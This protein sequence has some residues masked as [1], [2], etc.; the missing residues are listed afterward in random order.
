[1][2]P[3]V[4][5]SLTLLLKF[6]L[7]G[8]LFYFLSQKGLLSL[9]ATR[10]AFQRWDLLLLAFVCFLTATLISIFRWQALLKAQ[11]I[12][13]PFAM[14]LKLSFVGYFFNVALPGAVSG[15]V[16]K[17]VYVAKEAPGKRAFAFSSIII[18]RLIG[19]S[20]LVMVASIAWGIS[21]M[22]PAI[23]GNASLWRA[24]ELTVGSAGLAVFIF[25]GYLFLVPDRHDWIAKMLR[26]LEGKS[27][28]FGSLTRIYEGLRNYSKHRG[29]VVGTLLIS[30]CIHVLVT[31]GVICCANAI[32]ETHIDYLSFYLVVPLGMII[33]AIPVLPAGIGTGHAAFLTLFKLLGSDRGVDVFN[34]YILSILI[35]AVLGGFVYLFSKS[36]YKVAQS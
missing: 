10:A 28:K 17:A 14:T 26:G 4:K 12:N 2:N 11:G 20:A 21:L 36:N 27:P 3:R 13:L 35:H 34:L 29:V 25:Y 7:V 1:M 33:T 23:S 8:L 5:S 9:S 22:S 16:V 30:M 18:D 24:I 32:G 6:S 19:I 31:A 15:D